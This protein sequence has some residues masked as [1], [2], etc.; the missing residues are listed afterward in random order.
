MTRENEIVMAH[1]YTEQDI[2]E[3]VHEL[4]N[5][6][7]EG[8]KKLNCKDKDVVMDRLMTKMVS[9]IVELKYEIQ[10]LKE[11]IDNKTKN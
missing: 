2:K 3:F 9:S 10:V 7:E 8:K 4:C 5:K 1:L 6:Y 11:K